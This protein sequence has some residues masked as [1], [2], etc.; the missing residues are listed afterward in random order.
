M[1]FRAL[2]IN[3][4]SELHIHQHVLEIL[5]EDQLL[6]LTRVGIRRGVKLK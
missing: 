3:K 4:P 6:S 1:S 5:Q 2:E